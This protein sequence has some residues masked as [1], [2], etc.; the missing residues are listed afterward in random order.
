MIFCTFRLV[1][2][3]YFLVKTV[4]KRQFFLS[5]LLLVLTVSLFSQIPMN[6]KPEP[7]LTRILFVFDCSQS[8]AGQWKSDKKINIARHILS[9]TVDSLEHLKHIQMALRVFGFQSPVPPQDCSDTRLLVPFGPN[10]ARAIKHELRYLMPK[11][12]TP[13]AHS[14]ALTARDFTPCAHCRNIVVLITDGIEACDGDPC[15]VSAELQKKGIILKPFVI[16]IGEDPNFRKTYNCV[17]QYYD[18]ADEEQ[19]HDVLNIVIRQALDRTTAQVNLLDIHGNPTETNVNMTFYNRVSGKVMANYYH[20]INN[21][22]N[23][24]TIMLDPLITYRLVVHTIPPVIVDSIKVYPGKHTI[25]AADAP[26][27]SLQLTVN[28]SMYKDKQFVVRKHGINKTINVQKLNEVEKYL[29]GKYDLEVLVLP[30]LN[31]TVNIKQS[32]TT[33]VEI[34]QPGILNVVFP[35]E[36]YASLYQRTDKGQI[37]VTNL[38]KDVITQSMYILPGDYVVVY[39][40]LYSKS[41]LY[42]RVKK[43]H[44]RSGSSQTLH[45]Y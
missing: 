9:A 37:W 11:G 45:F 36:G 6:K 29:V 5:G 2:F 23:P 44:I 34:P 31:L 25:I 10:N 12:T 33:T 27:G 19:F 14:L 22:G 18:A 35:K 16:G 26:Q 21:R 7:P 3:K 17:G 42:T 4:I 13:I 32:T 39:R 43:V 38:K 41:V 8:M 1:F 20:T 28:G 15:A 40:P 24:D 30:R